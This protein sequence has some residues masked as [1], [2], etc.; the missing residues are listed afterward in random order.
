M[1]FY[2]FFED[3]SPVRRLKDEY[4]ELVDDLNYQIKRIEGNIKNI[5]NSIDDLHK[6]LNSYSSA[7]GIMAELYYSKIEESINNYKNI[8]ISC[9]DALENV[10]RRRNQA[11]EIRDKLQYY[12][13]IEQRD[14][15]EFSL[16]EISL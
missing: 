5:S 12:Y 8:L 11:I 6:T 7:K 16:G 2:W 14:N 13:Q 15:V 3:V 1:A 4:C 10:I 9:E